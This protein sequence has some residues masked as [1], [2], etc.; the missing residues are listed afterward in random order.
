MRPFPSLLF[1]FLWLL[2]NCLVLFPSTLQATINNS[3]SL[4][5][6]V[7]TTG[8]K[9][10][11]FDQWRPTAAYLGS[12]LPDYS[13]HIVC[14]DYN[15]VDKAV[16]SGQVDFT[17]T[18]PSV[19]VNLEYIFGIT[20]IATLKDRGNNETSTQYGSV[21][22]TKA[23]RTDIRTVV[24]LKGKRFAAVHQ[25]SF[26][27]WLIA[28]RYLKE[29]GIDP[30][31]DFAS[32]DF[33]GQHERVVLAVQEG[34]VD[35]GAIRTGVLEQMADEGKIDLKDFEVID[36]QPMDQAS[37]FEIVSPQADD[38]AF[39]YM[40]TTNL[41]PQW[42]LAKVYHVKAE[43]AKKVMI[44]F[45]EITPSSNAALASHSQGWVIPLDYFPVHKCLQ[46]L[47]VPPY[48]YVEPPFSLYQFYQKY[49]LWVYGFLG[50]LAI[51][52]GG[53]V[54]MAI[55]NGRLAAAMARLAKEHREKEK[56][57]AALNEFKT[58]LDKTN[59]CVFIFDPDTLLFLYVNQGGLQQVGYSFD[60]MLSMKPPDIAPDFTEQQ[61]KTLITPLLDKS[62]D[63][64][65]FITKHKTKKGDL[66]PVEI[67]L[68][69]IIPPG[70]K[71]RCVAMVRNISRRLAERR[72]REQLQGR[73]LSEQKL[74]SV[75]Q[76]AAG[77]AHEINTPSQYLGSNIDFLGESFKEVDALITQYD[78]LLQTETETP[79]SSDALIKRLAALRE[80][81]DWE[82]LKEEIPKAID[83]SLEGITKIRSIILAMKEFSHP[84]TKEKQQ[85]DLNRLIETTVTIASNEWKY[86]ADIDK[87]LDDHLPP[88]LCLPNEMGQVFLNILVNAA[89]AV[90]EKMN[91]QP[92]KK[93]GRITITSHV[94]AD[95]IEITFA[96]TGCGIP[97]KIRDKIFDPFFTTKEV[98][99]GT[100]QGLAIAHD[101]IVN[102]HGGTI[103]FTSTEGQGSTFIIR[104]PADPIASKHHQVEPAK[105][106][107]RQEQ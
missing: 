19:Y 16:Y 5:I 13:V 23:R 107:A 74:A 48:T 41:Y 54:Y 3:A 90:T 71:G 42:A 21:L 93:K 22:I 39:P 103:D 31:K 34:L 84:G 92:D 80:Q 95:Q 11:C 51:I 35:V 73:L 47:K 87:Q 69:Y 6:G 99:R 4:H 63:S 50:L 101:I 26:G 44:A 85:T 45:L 105:S 96:D 36:P 8:S 38:Q 27:G 81:S 15:E 24:D 58:T 28:W 66:I 97:Q 61:V 25:M 37:E 88:I 86:A 94:I 77:I 65:E 106:S 102:K 70:G 100:G 49:R 76:L 30:F 83:Q 98:G 60:E 72:E 62:K 32:L 29:R 91:N 7:L 79:A 68:Q 59:D 20:R 14:L 10:Q 1:Q 2:F 64:I 67:L 43:L 89:H 12:V 82:Y 9:G 53:S 33:L 40:H 56:T 75:G 17:I 52:L 18:N 104:L 57:V 78:R 55:L 46:E